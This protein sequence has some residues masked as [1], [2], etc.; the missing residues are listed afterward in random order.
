[1]TELDQ[2]EPTPETV[3]RIVAEL[4]APKVLP[5]DPLDVAL[6]RMQY[7]E[8][9]R[10]RIARDNANRARRAEQERLERQRQIAV[11]QR[12]RQEQYAREAEARDRAHRELRERGRL[13]ELAGEWGMYKQA[14][15]Q[16][17]A[18]QRRQAALE[19]RWQTINE[20]EQQITEQ[21]T[22]PPPIT[23]HD[24]ISIDPIQPSAVPDRRGLNLP[25]GRRQYRDG[26][27]E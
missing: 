11:Q 9:E 19:Q 13:A 7:E 8:R 14:L 16:A 22:P 12:Q 21:T 17:A 4:S 2:S 24:P 20:L 25:G 18:E 27:R 3:A 1:M 23:L 26:S 6:R 15:D 5:I 10:Q